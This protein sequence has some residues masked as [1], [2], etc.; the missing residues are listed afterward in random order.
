MYKLGGKLVGVVPI[1]FNRFTE[2]AQDALTKRKGGIKKTREQLIEEA[3]NKLYPSD[4]GLVCLPRVNLEASLVNG[5]KMAGQKHGRKALWRYLEAMV[6]GTDESFYFTDK[7]KP[8]GIDIRKGTNPNTRNAVMIYRPYLDGGWE[9]PF[10]L[11]VT[12]DIIPAEQ[13]KDALEFAGLCVGLCDYR[14]KF[15]RFVVEWE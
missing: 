3:P 6:F 8:D 5:S 4:N 7:T 10:Q 12:N 11:L 15:G 2:E 14:P 13:V 9:L 1:L